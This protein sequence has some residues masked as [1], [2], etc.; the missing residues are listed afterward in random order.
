MTIRF[1]TSYSTEW[2]PV[3]SIVIRENK[4]RSTSGGMKPVPHIRLKFR[5]LLRSKNIKSTVIAG[6]AEHWW[7]RI[8]FHWYH[9]YKYIIK[10]DVIDIILNRVF[11][12]SFCFER[13]ISGFS[14]SYNLVFFIAETIYNK[15]NIK[16][17]HG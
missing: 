5:D 12:M 17:A 1:Y 10:L 13:N 2:K 15:W 9:L 11:K 14:H 16:H 3:A 8:S 7:I 6:G 4:Q